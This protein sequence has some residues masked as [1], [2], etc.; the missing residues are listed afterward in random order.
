MIFFIP[1][2]GRKWKTETRHAVL[3]ELWDQVNNLSPP[4]T[5]AR[6]ESSLGYL[7][8]S[9]LENR[10]SYR[11]YPTKSITCYYWRQMI[12]SKSTKGIHTD[13]VLFVGGRLST[14]SELCFW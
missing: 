7:K 5:A 13:D 11:G 12:I 3:N 6:G 1:K 4:P 14:W 9:M 8:Q 10:Y 2:N